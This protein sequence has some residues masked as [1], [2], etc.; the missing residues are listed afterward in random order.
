M[1]IYNCG[2]KYKLLILSLHKRASLFKIDFLNN[3][4]MLID[5]NALQI[6]VIMINEKS[7]SGEF[8]LYSVDYSFSI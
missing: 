2:Q 4:P 7:D 5:M 1:K 3:I 8:H 6:D